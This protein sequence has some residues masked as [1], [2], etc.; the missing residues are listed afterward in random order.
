M[1]VVQYEPNAESVKSQTAP[2]LRYGLCLSYQCVIR[3]DL[4]QFYLLTPSMTLY[5]DGVG[6]ILVNSNP[7]ASSNERYSG[8][9][10]VPDTGRS[11]FRRDPE[12]L[13]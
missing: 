8:S 10:M 2:V 13:L 5:G 9:K 6:T 4:S 3:V 7:A 12:I 1:G 11:S